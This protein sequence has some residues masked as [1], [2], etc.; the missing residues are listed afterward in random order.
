MVEYA[1]LFKAYFGLVPK[2]KFPPKFHADNSVQEHL[3]HDPIFPPNV[4]YK[5]HADLWSGHIRNAALK[6][7]DLKQYPSKMAIVERAA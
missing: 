4:R 7:R 6:Y 2:T 5:D 1:L 3:F